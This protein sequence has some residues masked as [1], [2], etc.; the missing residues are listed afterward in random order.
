M[1]PHAPLG[2]AVE[3]GEDTVF[4]PDVKV[5]DGQL[6]RGKDWTIEALLT[7]GHASNHVA[8]A[9]LEENAL[10]P[11]DHVMGWSTTV[12]IPPDGDMGEYLASLDK[13][14]AGRF[15]VL[16]PTH[17]PPVT[18]VEPF[19]DAYRAHRLQREAQILAELA[20]GVT[21]IGAMVP[22]LYAAVDQR[23]WPA[24]AHSVYAH[25]LHLVRTGRAT[26]AGEPGL[27]SDYR[28]A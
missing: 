5:E 10:F 2:V 18:E 8:Y 24:A 25:L 21:R 4:R 27:D 13:V 12:V 3:E 23:L 16:W 22:R 9:L 11:G 26:A 19:L 28:L 20:A 14:R 15:E 17:G 7:P 1:T 6:V